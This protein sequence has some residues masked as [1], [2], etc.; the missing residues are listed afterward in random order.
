M[1]SVVVVL[2]ASIWAMIP[3]LRTLARSTAVRSVATDVY[4][5]QSD[6]VGLPPVMG[7][8]LIG[9]GHL[10]GV[11]APLDAGAEAVARVEQLVHQPLGH[12]LLAAL[13]RVADDPSQGEGGAA[14][15]PHLHRHLVG[16]PAHAPALDLD[17]R[18]D[19]VECSLERDHRVGAGLVAATFQRTIDNALG[20]GF[21]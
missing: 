3:M 7:E 1:R 17:G 21:L 6:P 8:G 9:L 2:P 13:P 15:R 20:D 12:G 16:R 18:L 14:A 4:L 5:S 10:V 19:V 11:L